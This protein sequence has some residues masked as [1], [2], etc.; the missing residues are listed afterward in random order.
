MASAGSSQLGSSALIHQSQLLSHGETVDVPKFTSMEPHNL[1]KALKASKAYLLRPTHVNRL[2]TF[3][4]EN[5]KNALAFKLNQLWSGTDLR[6]VYDSPE[7]D[8]RFVQDLIM[9]LATS[10]EAFEKVVQSFAM[11]D[12]RVINAANVLVATS[13]FVIGLEDYDLLLHHKEAMIDILSPPSLRDVMNR[14]KHRM[15]WTDFG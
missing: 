10:Q 9:F 4:D 6:R 7:G 15:Y 13:N 2:H 8:D 14:K 11:K 5:I 3:V 12:T 1:R